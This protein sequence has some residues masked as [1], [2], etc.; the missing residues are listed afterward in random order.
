M[1]TT[2][3]RDEAERLQR[4]RSWERWVLGAPSLVEMAYRAATTPVHGGHGLGGDP[5]VARVRAAA[6]RAVRDADHGVEA[7]LGRAREWL[8]SVSGSRGE[9]MATRRLA[10]PWRAGDLNPFQS[11][12]AREAERLADEAILRAIGYVRLLA[13]RGLPAEGPGIRDG[14]ASA[15]AAVLALLT[16]GVALGSEEIE[17]A[18][19]EAASDLDISRERVDLALRNGGRDPSAENDDSGPGM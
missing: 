2:V 11:A 10:A 19:S 1:A 15:E 3:K 8:L 18:A 12:T 5:I 17:R 7:F 13:T 9:E 4:L 14:R 16:A 6:D